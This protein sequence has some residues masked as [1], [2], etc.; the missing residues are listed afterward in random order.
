[1]ESLLIRMPK[2]KSITWLRATLNQVKLL[3]QEKSYWQKQHTL[4]WLASCRSN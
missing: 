4:F 3:R 2:K 1:V